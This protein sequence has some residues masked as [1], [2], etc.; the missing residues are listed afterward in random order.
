MGATQIVPPPPGFVLE[1][2]PPLPPGFILEGA[3]SAPPPRAGNLEIAK[4]AMYKG[5]A[6]IPDM[7]LNAPQNLINLAGAARGVV[8]GKPE[9]SDVSPTPDIIRGALEKIGLISNAQPQGFG[10]KALDVGLQGATGGA[11]TGGASLPRTIV[12]ALMGG[13]GAEAAA[14]TEAVT[15]SPAAGV[16]AGLL[17]PKGAAKVAGGGFN[18]RPDV[19]ALANENVQMTP[20][21]MAGGVF[22]RAEDALTSVPLL[23]DLIKSAQR[24]GHE[25]FGRAAVNRSLA[26]VGDK[27]PPRLKGNDAIGYAN[28]ALGN[29]YD[30]ILGRSK[31]SL[32]GPTGQPANALPAPGGSPPTLRQE[33]ANLRQ[34]SQSLPPAQRDQF[35][36]I[37]DTEISGKMGP[38][39]MAAGDTIKSI[40]SNLGVAAKN[41]QQSPNYD[42]RTMAGAVK[43]AQAAFR[44]A[45]ARENPQNADELA[46]TNEGWANFKRP[47][48]A[49]SSVAAKD[50]VF[51]PA[52]LH[53]AVKALDK[54]KD[55]SKFA[56]GDAL[57]QD[58]SQA[59]KNVLSPTVPDSGTPYRSL[60]GLVG[61]GGIEH[62]A[63]PMAAAA[64][65][66]TAVP[67]LPG[68]RQGIQK[69][70]TAPAKPDV[71][72]VGT[73]AIVPL[74]E[75]ESNMHPVVGAIVQGYRFKG[76][77]P[78]TPANWEPVQ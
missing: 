19:R 72:A 29:R 3:Q 73:N 21:Q 61:L 33:I 78:N 75:V 26:P 62:F 63:S 31:V 27:L 1:G 24:Q 44:R 9:F 74:A 35:N 25:S 36:R 71:K 65:G 30:S 45:L 20:G 66:A 53:G 64:L 42:D 13:L 4:N 49:A 37:L 34:M 6:G 41:L 50:G 28:D 48:R 43:E 11:L 5:A 56:R 47:E 40:E 55:K 23:G 70:V 69:V 58:F 17:A 22:Q 12:G 8:T 68:V 14:G 7:L 57:M 77:D 67:Y 39:G 76:G 51:T 60:L 10:Q 15:K 54:S 38:G 46:Q 2:M 32:D 59:G 18:L 52:Q 16:T